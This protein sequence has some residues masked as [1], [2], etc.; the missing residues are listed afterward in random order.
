MSQLSVEERVACEAVAS[1]LSLNDAA[2][3]LN[4]T[5]YLLQ[6]TLDSVVELIGRWPEVIHVL[7]GSLQDVKWWAGRDL[8]PRRLSSADLQRASADVTTCA[9]T[10]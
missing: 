7:P 6:R 2:A 1:G 3:S 10:S 4:T 8:N 9:Q 5:L